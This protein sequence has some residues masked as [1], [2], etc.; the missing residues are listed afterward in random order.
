MVIWSKEFMEVRTTSFFITSGH[1]LI[2][3]I[4]KLKWLTQLFKRDIKACPGKLFMNST[5]YMRKSDEEI[6]NLS[7]EKGLIIIGWG[8]MSESLYSEN[9]RLSTVYDS[10]EVFF[11]Y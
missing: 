10:K 11:I 9:Q 4:Q 8:T 3:F 6:A 5:K 1:L 2:L 7:K